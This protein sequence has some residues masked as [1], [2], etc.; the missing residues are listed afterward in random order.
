MSL[1]AWL[2]RDGR[3]LLCA[4]TDKEVLNGLSNCLKANGYSDSVLQTLAPE[5]IVSKLF[6][7]SSQEKKI[8]AGRRQFLD[9]LMKREA[10]MAALAPDAT[11]EAV[12]KVGN[13]FPTL[14]K[15]LLKELMT[16][17]L[18]GYYFLPSVGPD[19][20]DAGF[21]VLMREIRHLPK[22]LADLVA[23]GTIADEVR[24]AKVEPY[25]YAGC[26][27]FSVED[28]AYPLGQLESP[29]IEHLMQV[30]SMLFA[31][32]GLPDVDP[33]LHEALW[34]FAVESESKK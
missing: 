28:F 29:H 10:I 2:E 1:R 12:R 31:R 30:F 23:N 14:R 32:I 18:T 13:Q 17:R 26:L 19:R 33:G 24:N 6:P 8:A 7:D 27:D 4:R 16:Q 25:E 22:A 15:N 5:E 11:I 34:K 21:V 20:G 9:T 3:D